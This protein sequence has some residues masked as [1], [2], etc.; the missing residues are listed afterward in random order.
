[1]CGVRI[2]THFADDVDRVAKVVEAEFV[3]DRVNSIDKRATMDPKQFGYLSVHYIVSLPAARAGLREYSR[4][5]AC[6]AEIQIRSVLQH[7]WAEIEHD[8]GYKS[9]SAVPRDT[10]RQFSRIAG[11]LEVADEGFVA[12]RRRLSDYALEVNAKIEY[13]SSELL[14]DAVSIKALIDSDN[15][16]RKIDDLVREA[17]K[18]PLMD[19]PPEIIAL[20]VSAASALGF[21]TIGDLKAAIQSNDAR[22]S[23]FGLAYIE[24]LPTGIRAVA[25]GMTVPLFLALSSM[26]KG[27]IEFLKQAYPLLQISD[28]GTALQ[29]RALQKA[30]ESIKGQ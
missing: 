13:K 19:L 20:Q 30:F 29:L 6:V 24:Q 1:V 12:L 4:Y 14:I 10:V 9:A 16:I 15:N 28:V 5:S 21:R 8:L 25:N 23:R 3:I 2:I 18:S 26:D 17:A 22:I 11:L 7:A 27:G